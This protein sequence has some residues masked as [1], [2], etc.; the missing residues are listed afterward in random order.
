MTN[1]D[2]SLNAFQGALTRFGLAAYPKGFEWGMPLKQFPQSLAWIH[3]FTVK[4][5]RRASFP[6]WSWAGW[7]GGVHYPVGLIA[8]ETAQ[9]DLVPRMIGINGKEVTLEGW[10]V[11]LD[12]RT[13]PFSELVVPGSDTAVGCVTERNFKHN[14]TIPSGRYRCLVA[15]RVNKETLRNGLQNQQ[16]FLVILRGEEG[17]AVYERQTVITVSR[18]AVEGKDFMEFSPEHTTVTLK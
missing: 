16:V 11:T 5:K 14:N 3:D 1:D 12:I 15:A 17:S 6:S 8:K 7:A 2:D 9:V 13:D 4:P 18:L 10:V